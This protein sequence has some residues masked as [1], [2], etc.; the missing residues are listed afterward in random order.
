MQS[1]DLVKA[2]KDEQDNVAS[3]VIVLEDCMD[4]TT[5]SN[6]NDCYEFVNL[7]DTVP[8]SPSNS[9]SSRSKSN[10]YFGGVDVA[11]P[12][13]DDGSSCTDESA[14]AV[15]CIVNESCETVYL[16]RNKKVIVV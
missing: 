1:S 5:T 16:V 9:S 10:Y 12:T 7:K 2:W 14:V 4:D 13:E 11:F 8:S 6:S 15:Y 3:Q